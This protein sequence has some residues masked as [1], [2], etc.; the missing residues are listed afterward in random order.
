MIADDFQHQ[1]LMKRCV[2]LVALFISVLYFPW[3]CFVM[4]TIVGGL[5]FKNYFESFIAGLFMDAF[6]GTN[7]V[8][9]HNFF[10]FFSLLSLVVLLITAILKEK[11]RFLQ[12]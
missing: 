11:I 10:L 8:S 1:S 6:Y 3:W 12:K 2:L 9:F 7:A 5:L 4:V